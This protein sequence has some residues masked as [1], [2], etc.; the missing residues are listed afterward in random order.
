MLRP[1]LAYIQ[2]KDAHL[3]TGEVVATGRGDSQM[4]ETT[5]QPRRDGFDGYFSLEP[6]LSQ[7]THWEASPDPNCSRY[8]AIWFVEPN[9]IYLVCTNKLVQR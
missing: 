6:H 5:R 2:I 7:T 9:H 4:I 3:A 1:H 8:S